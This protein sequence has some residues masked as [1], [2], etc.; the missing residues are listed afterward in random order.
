MTRRRSVRFT[1]DGV[2]RDSSVKSVFRL[3]P[4]A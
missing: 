4:A 3:E 1:A 2:G